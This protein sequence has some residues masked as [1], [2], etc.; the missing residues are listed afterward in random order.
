M[1]PRSSDKKG[2][3]AVWMAGWLAKR[4]RPFIGEMRK[5][6]YEVSVI[7]ST[8][9][10]RKLVLKEHKEAV[11]EVVSVSEVFDRFWEERP[12]MQV[13]EVIEKAKRNE[14]CYP[15]PLIDLIKADRH[16]GRGFVRGGWYPRSLLSESVDYFEY[17]DM[18]NRMLH[19]LDA[20]FSR[21]RFHVL[22]TEVASFPTK[23]ACVVARAK[24]VKIRT[25]HPS[26]IEDLYFFAHN[27]F[28]EIPPLE[29]HYHDILMNGGGVSLEGATLC[30]QESYGLAKSEI[31]TY[32]E[33]GS[34]RVTLKG[35]LQQLVVQAYRKLRKYD[36]YSPYYVRDRVKAVW[37]YHRGIREFEKR[38]FPGMNE[39]DGKK[40]VFYPLQ[41]EPESAL[42]VMSPEFSH[43]EYL[44]HLLASNLPAGWTLV[45]KEHPLALGTR[46]P[47]FYETVEGYP[48]VVFVKPLDSAKEWCSKSQAVAMITGSVG[49]EA[50]IDG[51]PVISFGKHNFIKML[52]YVFEV[53]SHETVRRAMDRIGRGEIPGEQER[54][55]QGC[56]LKEALKRISFPLDG[57]PQ[58]TKGDEAKAA[59]GMSL[60]TERLIESLKGEG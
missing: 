51:V 60:F 55:R 49:Y 5:R 18:I 44:I 40:V 27:E 20:F 47:G 24:G 29:G 32:L 3:I 1:D 13:Q 7:C 39:F 23:A 58:V 11:K 34:L 36:V 59:T 42:L 56:A 6:G 41:L 17:L 43:Q 57:S 4:L 19:F 30:Q 28:L 25:P 33:Y 21:H 15:E 37:R 9:V 48:N 12:K 45:V 22:L 14:D 46:P 53:D 52:D 8:E 38:Q 16:M 54:K 26:R 10:D 50:A 31:G 35:I 2:E